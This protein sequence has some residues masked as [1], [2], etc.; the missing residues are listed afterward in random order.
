VPFK[1]RYALIPGLAFGLAQ[2]IMPVIGWLGG[3]LVADF[4][5]AVDHWVAFGILLII[6]VKFIW[7]SREEVDVKVESDLKPLAVLIAAFA[8]SIDACAVGFS[9]S[10]AQDPIVLPSILF[11]VVTFFCSVL[12]VRLGSKL[13]E[14]FGNKFMII[15]GCILILIGVKILVEHLWMG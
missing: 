2:G 4:I 5:Q 9:L 10:M 12:C 15:G 11:A 7:D 3:E 8:T 13:S 14:K 1:W 6:G